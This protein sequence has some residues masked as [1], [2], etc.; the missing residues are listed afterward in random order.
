MRALLCETRTGKP[1]VDLE[2]SVWDYDCGILAPDKLS[3]TVPA[4]TPR[5]QSMDLLE[6]LTPYKYSVALVDESVEGVPVVC[7]AGPITSR[8]PDDDSD[9]RTSFKVMARGPEVLFDYWHIRA[10]PGWP[11]IDAAGKPTGTYDMAFTGMSL[12]TI[13]KKLVQE[14]AKWVGNEL[15]LVFEADRS[16]SRE[17]AR[18]EAVDGKPLLEALDQIGDRSDGV[19]WALVPEIDDLDQVTYRLVTG[20][21]A[22]QIIVGADHLTW[23][24]GGMSPDVRGV[25]PNDLVG[26]VA[27]DAIFHAGKGDDKIMLARASDTALVDDG[28]PRLEVWDSSHSSVTVQ[29]TLQAWADGRVSGVASRPSFDVRA[30][31]ADGVRYGDLVELASQGHWFWPDGV[32]TVRVMSVSRSSSDPDWVGVS[33]V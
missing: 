32:V 22:A 16:G 23:N 27:T 30:V 21:D 11:L 13:I 5:A 19:E 7:A 1:V 2:V 25:E 6:L 4:Y 31:R 10:F 17:Y 33:L 9:G 15:P 18:H 14:R 29:A 26:E 20:T 8:V 28:W 3:V 12:G 24:V